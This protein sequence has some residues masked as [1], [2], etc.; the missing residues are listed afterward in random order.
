M[1]L[2]GGMFTWLQSESI[3]STIFHKENFVVQK[4]T[5]PTVLLLLHVY[6][7][8]WQRFYGAVA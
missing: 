1:Q 3:V 2:W 8:P 6:S 4:T 5:H 7:L